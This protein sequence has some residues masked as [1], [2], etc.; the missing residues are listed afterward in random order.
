M[1]NNGRD[2]ADWNIANPN[3]FHVYQIEGSV[4]KFTAIK[5]EVVIFQVSPERAVRIHRPRRPAVV[6]A[7]RVLRVP[8]VLPQIHT[9]LVRHPC[10]VPLLVK[11]QGNQS[12]R[13]A[14]LHRTCIRAHPSSHL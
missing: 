11:M 14:V 12:E 10:S 2:E 5:P 9:D 8:C 1:K 3:Q 7:C 13:P 4:E 6:S